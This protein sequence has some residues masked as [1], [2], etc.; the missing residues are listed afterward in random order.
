[1][2]LTRKKPFHLFALAIFLLAAATLVPGTG[3]E[4]P[5]LA[6]AKQAT[7]KKQ[8]KLVPPEEP[9]R[10]LQL[11]DLDCRT[12]QE[13]EKRVAELSTSGANALI[14]RVFQ[15][16]G[17]KYYSFIKP[18]YDRGV[19]FKTQGVPVV[20]DVL[21]PMCRIAHQNGLAIIA[22]MTTRYANYGREDDNR[23]RCMAWD[24]EKSDFVKRK[25]YSPLLPEVQKRLAALYTDLAKYPIDG[26]L[27]QDDLMLKHT[28]GMNP[29]ARRLFYRETGK[30]ADPDRFF[31]KVRKEG[32]RWLVGEYTEEFEHWCRW[33][34][35]VMVRLAERVRRAVHSRRPYK[36]VGINVFYET[37]T[38]PKKAVWWFS[39]DIDAIISS[40]L[41]FYAVMFYHRQMSS[42]LRMP[43]EE[44]YDLIARSLGRLHKKVDRAQRVWVKAQ[45]VDWETGARLPHA[46]IAQVLDRA[47]ET[48][49]FGMVA[50]PVHRSLDLSG[51]RKTFY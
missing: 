51:L 48:G 2:R 21:G 13:V 31:K 39:Q 12:W 26:V 32:G 19:Y 35:G 11:M 5:R 18:K 8:G 27:I 29:E 10:G 37:V 33:K 15:D 20:A 34:S 4:D 3:S 9:V 1:M 25:G 6:R 44:V 22:W 42:E 36:P 49:P 38:D 46:E 17:D 43:R 24:F 30:A 28:E 45:S 41:D 7:D 14:I 40:D 47:K 16:P 50:V 23:L